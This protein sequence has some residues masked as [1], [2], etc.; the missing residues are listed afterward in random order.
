MRHTLIK[1]GETLLKEGKIPTTLH[2]ILSGRCWLRKLVQHDCGKSRLMTLASAEAGESVGEDELRRKLPMRTSVVASQ[3]LEVLKLTQEEY[4]QTIGVVNRRDSYVKKDIIQRSGVF[5]GFQDE[6]GEI[7][8]LALLSQRR[9]F[10]RGD[11]VAEIG[12][13]ASMM[14]L[15]VRGLVDAIRP[16]ERKIAKSK[17][18]GRSV[19]HFD[20]VIAT[21]TFGKCIGASVVLDPF[22]PR[23]PATF[24]CTTAVEML[25]IGKEAFDLR[26][27]TS[28]VMSSLE[29]ASC[30]SLS[31]DACMRVIEDKRKH[32]DNRI[33]VL[34]DFRYIGPKRQPG[35]KKDERRV[36]PMKKLVPLNQITIKQQM[37]T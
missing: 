26:K 35:V 12:K 18:H 23:Y 29:R 34:R 6:D 7:S 30:R 32:A 10:K 3:D 16:V 20:I 36:S 13:P 21:L 4:A 33:K 2:I 14:Y 8:R 37:M 1:Q 5:D 27:I 15:I 11:V 17:E 31:I 28:G 9:Y 19:E 25:L 22:H 24:K